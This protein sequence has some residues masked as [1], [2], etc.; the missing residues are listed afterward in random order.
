MRTVQ[1]NLFSANPSSG[2]SFQEPGTPSRFGRVEPDNQAPESVPLVVDVD[3]SLLRTDLLHEGLIKL[4][5]HRPHRF[6]GT[7]PHLRRGR[8]AFKAAVARAADLNVATLP[9]CAEVVA[10][11]RSARA[12]GRDVVL[13]SGC[14]A[15]YAAELAEQHGADVALCSDGRLNRVGAAKL[16]LLGRWHQEFDYVG[17]SGAD[18]PVWAAAR[19]AMVVNASPRCS[20]ALRRVRPDAQTLGTRASRLSAAF[21]AARAHQWIKNALI[22]LPALAAHLPP[23]PRLLGTLALGVAAF[24]AAASGIY[25]LNDLVDLERDRMHRRKR[26]RPLAAGELPVFAGL[27]LACALLVAAA[28]TASALPPK[29]G[30]L[31]AMYVATSL[32]YSLALKT[33]LLVDVVT[34]A[35]LYTIRVVAGSALLDVRLSPPFVAFSVFTFFALAVAK[36][37]VELLPDG[38]PAVGDVPGRAYRPS[39]AGPLTALGAAATVA[40]ALVFSLYVMSPEAHDLYAR[41]ELLWLILPLL[42]YWHARVWIFAVRGSLHDDPIVFA[43]R[44]RVSAYVACAG[45]GVFLAAA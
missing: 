6:A 26:F 20:R 9:V 2:A 4:L 21:R 18:L 8:A 32:A 36:R 25:V 19:T 13:A 35:G 1:T 14:D 16:E 34:L 33:R 30:A 12:A 43:L 28:L 3:G 45:V 39:D 15:S 10:A 24:S 23:T 29:F 31:L 37:V 5:F 17:N 7:L 42:L 27:A 44:D 40:S 22:L 11:M 41:H 38:R